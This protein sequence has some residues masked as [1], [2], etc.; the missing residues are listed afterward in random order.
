LIKWLSGYAIARIVYEPTGAYHG[1]F[2]RR[3][4]EAGFPLAKVNPRHARRFAE[5]VGTQAKTDAVDAG[6][7]ARFGALIEPRLLTA[8]SA[9]GPIMKDL[10]AARRALV[11]DRTA[12]RNRSLQRRLALLKAQAAERLNQIKRQIQA[13]DAA[14][15]EQLDNDVALKTRFNILMSIPG[16]GQATP[17]TLLTDMPELGA[18]RRQPRWPGA[19]GSRQRTMARQAFHPGRTSA[20]PPRPLHAGARRSPLQIPISGA[21]SKLSPPPASPQRSPSSPS[22]ESSSSSPMPSSEKAP[23]GC[24]TP[25]DQHGYSSFRVT[26][27][28]PRGGGW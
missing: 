10:L 22:C 21:S 25:L 27:D 14:L 2:E 6:L 16:L 18:M 13:I 11:K 4:L 28:T 26:R 15:R 23:L 17:F 3:F 1:G 12:A 24:Q 20:R 5:A 9:A 19:H 7:L 8:S